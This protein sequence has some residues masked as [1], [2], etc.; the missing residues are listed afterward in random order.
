[1]EVLSPHTADIGMAAAAM[2]SLDLVLSIDGMPVHLAGTLGRPTWVLLKA[3]ADWRWMAD[4]EDSP[5]YPTVRLFRQAREG[6]WDSLVRAVATALRAMAAMREAG[7][8]TSPPDQANSAAATA[9]S[10]GSSPAP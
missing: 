8:A 7:S 9:S 4:R 5:W 6:D 1:V 3:E 10:P 2:C